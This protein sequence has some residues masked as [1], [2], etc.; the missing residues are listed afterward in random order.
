LPIETNFF[1]T[2]FNKAHLLFK[3]FMQETNEFLPEVEEMSL[4]HPK[5]ISK[6]EKQNDYYESI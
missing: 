2:P 4:Y 1:E 6:Q 5:T 3:S